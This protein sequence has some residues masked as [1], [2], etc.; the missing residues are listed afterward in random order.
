MCDSGWEVTHPTMFYRV[1]RRR[2]GEWDR[3]RQLML[4][5]VGVDESDGLVLDGLVT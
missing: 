2:V 1:G 4:C 5:R 3:L